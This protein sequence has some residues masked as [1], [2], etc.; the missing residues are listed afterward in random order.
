M[1]GSFE[2]VEAQSGGHRRICG[3]ASQEEASSDCRRSRAKTMDHQP[4]SE[5]AEY[6]RR[7]YLHP[8]CQSVCA[9]IP[10]RRGS[11]RNASIQPDNK[12][13]RGGS[14]WC[15]TPGPGTIQPWNFDRASGVYVASSNRL[16]EMLG[17][18]SG[19]SFVMLPPLAKRYLVR[20]TVAEPCAAAFLPRVNIDRSRTLTCTRVSTFVKL[21][22][23]VRWIAR[24]NSALGKYGSTVTCTLSQTTTAHCW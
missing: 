19:R 4:R 14:W 23:M 24:R 9:G 8:P 7:E 15:G 20:R 21:G 18:F 11:G 17:K 10:A 13:Y 1:V 3:E 5:N 2:V 16:G 12:R 6:L 22:L